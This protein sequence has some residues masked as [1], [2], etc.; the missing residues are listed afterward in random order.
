MGHEITGEVIEAR[1]GATEFSVG[2]RLSLAADI[3]CGKCYYCERSLY[4][5]CDNLKILG[6]DVDGGFAEY[7]ALT[8]DIL[9]RGIVNHLPPNLSFVDG[10]LSEP[11]CSVLAAQDRLAVGLGDTVVV[12]GG[13]PIGCLHAEIAHLRGARQVILVEPSAERAANAA[14]LFHVDRVAAPQDAVEAVQEQTNGVGADAAIVATPAPEASTQAVELVRKRGR[15]AL[16]GGLPRQNPTVHLNGNEIH[17]NEKTV[18]GTFSYHPR[19]HKL[20][21]ELLSSGKIDPKKLIATYSL[22]DARKAIT[23]ARQGKVL[24][25]VL[26][27][28][29][30][31]GP[32]LFRLDRDER[33][34][35]S[36][37]SKSHI[38][39]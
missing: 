30:E 35:A 17:Y 28:D 11:M 38:H 23:D 13:G 14:A 27:P 39:R 10:A 8:K 20:A 29:L 37:S 22:E 4:N 32:A 1:K 36:T 26:V 12:L 34:T 6:R 33:S 16:F 25:A 18:V 9:E 15:I 19:Y 21:L 3:R 7:M 5:L 24:K 31:E 2:D